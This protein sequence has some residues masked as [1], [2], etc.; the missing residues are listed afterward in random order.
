M[1][2]FCM[3]LDRLERIGRLQPLK[4]PPMP[5]RQIMRQMEHVI[6]L[7]LAT[8]TPKKVTY[9]YNGYD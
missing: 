8:S 4:T 2:H 6:G 9:E 5:Q 3:R 7:P 1:I